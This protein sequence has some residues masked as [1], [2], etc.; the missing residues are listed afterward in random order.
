MGIRKL[1]VI[2][3]VLGAALTVAACGSN[4]DDEGTAGSDLPQGSEPVDINP[5]DFTTEIDNPY[6]PMEV[7]S[8]WVY[9]ET[10]Q[11]GAEQ[12]VE[13]TITNKTKRIANGVEARVVRDVVT[14]T[15]TNEA[16]EITDDWYAQDSDGNVWYMGEETAEYENGKLVTRAGSFEAGVDG[17]Q[18]GIIMPADPEVGQS[19]RQEYYKGKAEDAGAVLSLDAQAEGPGRSLLADADDPGHEPARAEGVRAQVL[20]PRRGPRAGGLGVRRNRPRGAAQLHEGRLTLGEIHPDPHHGPALQSADLHEIADLVDEP[21]AASL[22]LERLRSAVVERRR[23]EIALVAHLA[24]ERVRLVPHS[25]RAPPRL[26]GAR[27]SS[28]AR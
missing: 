24:H 2:C 9:R 6:W 4:G 12:R 3:V 13:V 19:Y 17:A 7:G 11:E 27:C 8:E 1:A 14:D 10:D 22:E 18:P 15:K 23:G 25:N 21:Q 5:D 28:P 16:V 20:C 26:R